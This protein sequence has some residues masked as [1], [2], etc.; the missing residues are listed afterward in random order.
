MLRL[1]NAPLVLDPQT[2]ILSGTPKE[3]DAGEYQVDIEVEIDGKGA[4]VQSF[5]LQV[6]PRGVP[7][8]LERK[9]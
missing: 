2:G 4:Y 7:L 1:G 3:K 8:L 9:D 5:P 6:K